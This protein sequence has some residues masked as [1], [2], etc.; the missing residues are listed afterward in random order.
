MPIPDFAKGH[1]SDTYADGTKFPAEIPEAH[2]RLA[3]YFV[4]MISGV[5]GAKI[6]YGGISIVPIDHIR[7]RDAQ[8]RDRLA[9]IYD[10]FGG[11]IECIVMGTEVFQEHHRALKVAM[12][13]NRV[14]IDFYNSVSAV[15]Y[16]AD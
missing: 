7:D 5:L 9:L 1:V 2:W 3:V 14:Y 11:D 16:P 8:R 12:A 10:G 13:A 15:I 6:G 4:S